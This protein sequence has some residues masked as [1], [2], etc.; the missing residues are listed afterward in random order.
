MSPAEPWD[1]GQLLLQ[2][3]GRQAGVRTS[4][5]QNEAFPTDGV[6]SRHT[7]CARNSRISQGMSEL[8]SYVVFCARSES[9]EHL[10]ACG[11]R[12]C[13]GCGSG[14]VHQGRLSNHEWPQASPAHPLFLEAWV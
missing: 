1:R 5:G 4:E 9:P 14:W 8:K 13:L 11:S 2:A 12:R 6:K 3:A 10:L 7:L